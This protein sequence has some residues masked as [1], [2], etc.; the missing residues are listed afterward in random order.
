M[1]CLTAMFETLISVLLIL[2]LSLDTMAI[3]SDEER[4]DD[5]EPML[6]QSTQEQPDSCSPCPEEER[7]GCSPG[8]N[9]PNIRVACRLTDRFFQSIACQAFVTVGCL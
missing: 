3:N 6:F 2:R 9:F 5:E 1:F 8:V 4:E 7:H